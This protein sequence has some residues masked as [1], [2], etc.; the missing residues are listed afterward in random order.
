[1]MQGSKGVPFSKRVEL[2]PNQSG[3]IV[4]YIYASAIRKLS[5]V[6]GL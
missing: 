4:V 3:T 2:G 5:Q 1:M 6:S